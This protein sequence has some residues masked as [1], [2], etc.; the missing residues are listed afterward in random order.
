MNPRSPSS[1]PTVPIEALV[2]IGNR[3]LDALVRVDVYDYA[4]CYLWHDRPL[5]NEFGEAI[6]ELR[7]ET[8]YLFRASETP[9]RD[10]FHELGHVIARRHRLVGNSEN[11]FNGSWE[12]D[13][14]KLIAEICAQR[15]WSGYLNL[16]A[17]SHPEFAMNAASELWAELFMLWHLHPECDEARLL[18]AGMRALEDQADFAAIAGLA[19]ELKLAGGG[20]DA[21]D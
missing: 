15:H 16:Y 12:K 2:A 7:G 18:D 14:A 21:S 9:V 11:G 10:L 20:S 5:F 3:H 17:L 4:S 6:A 13:N 19:G 8:I 1:S